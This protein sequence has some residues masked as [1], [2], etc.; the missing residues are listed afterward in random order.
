MNAKRWM[1]AAVTLSL[2]AALLWSLQAGA[3]ETFAGANACNQC[4]T[5]WP[6][7]THTT[8]GAMPGVACADCHAV[9]P[10]TPNECIACHDRTALFQGHG[11]L[12]DQDGYQ[13]GFCHEGVGAQVRT[14]SGLKDDFR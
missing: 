7:A 12:I 8:H 6:G 5:D 1:V 14:W 9:D 4:H 13:C 2:A 11:G 3:Y 10:I